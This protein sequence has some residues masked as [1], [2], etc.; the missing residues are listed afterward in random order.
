[1]LGLT[2]LAQTSDSELVAPNG[3]PEAFPPESDTTELTTEQAT[4]VIAGLGIFMLIVVILGLVN[5]I[6]FVL[7]LIHLAKNPSVPNRTLW[8]VLTVFIPFAGMIYYLGPRRSY[9]KSG[10]SSA[11][12]AGGGQSS[13]PQS[14]GPVQPNQ[15]AQTV[16]A[17]SATGA[18]V[19]PQPTAP[20]PENEVSSATPV[21][22]PTT[23]PPPAHVAAAPENPVQLP[24]SPIQP[25]E[26]TAQPEQSQEFQPSAP[27]VVEPQQPQQPS[28][29]VV[30]PTPPQQEENQSP[31]SDSQ[32]TNNQV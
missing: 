19:A 26:V 20:A 31:T 12:Q 30:V 21:T 32:D 17:A 1:M 2:L 14:T 29:D 3:I 13:Q 22:S 23:P 5:F 11:P 16:G 6:F 28:P 9:N 25:P 24:P 4:G 15:T 8:I 27:Q 18:A 7:A 10:N